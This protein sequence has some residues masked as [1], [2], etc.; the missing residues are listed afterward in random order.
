MALTVVRAV[1]PNSRW[2]AV[3]EGT[4]AV[5]SLFVVLDDEPD[6]RRTPTT[7]SFTPLTVTSWPAAPPGENSS[8]AL[9][10]PSPATAATSLTYEEVRKRRSSSV[11]LRAS[12]HDALV[13]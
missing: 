13:P 12:S 3:L 8:L 9:S 7:F 4:S 11:R 10:E 6:G 2:A 1:P 5:S